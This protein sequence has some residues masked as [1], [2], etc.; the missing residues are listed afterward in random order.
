MIR[1]SLRA[2]TASTPA[3]SILFLP[4]FDLSDLQ[5]KEDVDTTS[6]VPIDSSRL[7]GVRTFN[8]FWPQ[9]LVATYKACPNGDSPPPILTSKTDGHR[10]PS[11]YCLR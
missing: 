11:A 2:S 6:P 8:S 5:P 7:E 4:V 1:P 9:R 10:P 3:L